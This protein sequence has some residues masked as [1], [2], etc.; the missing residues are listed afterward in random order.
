MR[1]VPNIMFREG[2]TFYLLLCAHSDGAQADELC[3]HIHPLS[4]S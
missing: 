1:S 4:R 3:V 2:V